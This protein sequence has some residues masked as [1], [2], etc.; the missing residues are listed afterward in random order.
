MIIKW[1]TVLHLTSLPQITQSYLVTTN[2]HNNV[3]HE[4]TLFNVSALLKIKFQQDNKNY[5]IA[6]I[7]ATLLFYH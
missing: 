4:E 7:L 5:N 2:D 1:E 6:N 3:N